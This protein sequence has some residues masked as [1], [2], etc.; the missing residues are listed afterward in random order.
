MTAR[1]I[2]V[3]ILMVLLAVEFALA[4]A[5]KLSP[6]SGW[7]RMFV[8]WGFPAWFRVAVGAIEIACAVALFIPRLRA[9]ACAVLLVVMAG[10]AVT[11]LTH[12]EPRRV[13]LNV[14]LSA[15]VAVLMGLGQTPS[16]S[17]D[18]RAGNEK[19]T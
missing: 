3:W 7:A 11:H 9:W 18:S 2:V 1:R 12:G 14:A 16:T 10:A 6:S 19:G 13:I 15:L 17:R 4:G 5:S 8:A